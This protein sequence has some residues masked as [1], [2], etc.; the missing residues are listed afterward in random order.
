MASRSTRRPITLAPSSTCSIESAGTSRRRRASQPDRTESASGVSGDVPYIAH[1]TRPT[2]RPRASATRNPAVRRRSTARALTVANLFPACEENPPPGVRIL[3]AP[4]SRHR[5]PG[6]D[7]QGDVQARQPCDRA[8]GD[9]IAAPLPPEGGAERDEQHDQ[10]DVG[11][12]EPD[13]EPRRIVVASVALLRVD[14]LRAAAHQH[15]GRPRHREPRPERR[16]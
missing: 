9:G 10:A 3:L 13:A 4:F 8:R 15:P 16:P 5:E 6:E 7:E 12:E 2:T 14:P 11:D 1:S